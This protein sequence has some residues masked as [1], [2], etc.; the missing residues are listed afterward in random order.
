VAE[1]NDNVDFYVNGI[2][3]AARKYNSEG[4]LQGNTHYTDG[5][6]DSAELTAWLNATAITVIGGNNQVLVSPPSTFQNPSRAY[7]TGVLATGAYVTLDN[8]LYKTIAPVG[9]SPYVAVEVGGYSDGTITLDP[10]KFTAQ[11]INIPLPIYNGAGVIIDLIDTG[12]GAGGYDGKADKVIIINKAVRTVAALPSL[13]AMTNLVSF[14]GVITSAVHKDLIDYPADIAVKDVVLTYTDNEGVLHVEK[15]NTV[16]GKLE[17]V[18]QNIM[19]T[20]DGA[21]YLLSGLS[22]RTNIF[23]TT[24]GYVGNTDNLSANL[25]KLAT[26]WLD[27]GGNIVAMASAEAI[28]YNAY[29][30]V[31]GYEYSGSTVTG[32]SAKARLLL[33]DGTIKVFD[34][35]PDALGDV[36]NQGYKNG[37]KN[38]ILTDDSTWGTLVKY[39]VDNNGAITLTPYGD[40]ANPT[41]IGTGNVA[42]Y[43]KGSSVVA[44]GSSSHYIT[45]STKVFYFDAAAQYNSTTNKAGVVTGYTRTMDIDVSTTV[46]YAVAA[47]TTQLE[48]IFFVTNASNL[49]SDKNYIFFLSQLP[50][51]GKDPTGN[52]DVNYYTGY[53]TTNDTAS[54]T[55]S[56]RSSNAAV[57]GSILFAGLYEYQLDAD[58]FVV[59]ATYISTGVVAG[60][61]QIITLVNP[62]EAG[63]GGY[64]SYGL[65]YGGGVTGGVIYDTNTKFYIVKYPDYVDDI[66]GAYNAATVPPQSQLKSGVALID[67]SG[68]GFF[69]AITRIQGIQPGKDPNTDPAAAIY[70]SMD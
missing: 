69:D 55:I 4:A 8:V 54:I 40:S 53:S 48:A 29:G 44:I 10:D 70:F 26:L 41:A 62:D 67:A 49:I 42:S 60:E 18:S 27:N 5:L 24:N 23:D 7:Y 45:A 6:F 37:G 1:L 30:I 65:P 34:V 22:G 39:K 68:A 16:T 56:T 52:I 59:K 20:V 15:A 36:P 32:G 61:G 3:R 57:I 2:W 11:D 31:I 51:A 66:F 13:N 12:D 38:T 50:T 19:V 64:I 14:P 9:V 33:Q 46:Y 17:R 25:N 58:G 21:F 35:A 47:N 43:K 28:E 63:T